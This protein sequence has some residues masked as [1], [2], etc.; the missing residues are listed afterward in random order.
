MTSVDR[1]T[2]LRSAAL[3]AAAAA[4]AACS[5]GGAA[6]PAPTAAAPASGHSPPS[7]PDGG[8]S[9]P[10]TAGATPALPA[11]MPFS[12]TAGPR[13]RPRVA[14]TFHG[15]GAPDLTKAI[16]DTTSA[17]GARI[18]VMA[19]GTWLDEQPQLA[20]S[21]LDGGNELGNHTLT[22]GNISGMTAEAAYAEIAGCADRLKRL[23][24]SPGRWFR[25][26]RAEACT[27]V[28]AAQ[29]RRAGYEHCLGYDL[30]SLDY[31]DPGA[32][33]VR[34]TVLDRVRPGSVVSLH[35][36]HRGTVEALP[37]ILAG[38]RARGLQAVT[39]TE[40]FT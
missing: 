21:V 16:L 4:V 23:T 38:L 29:A 18:T 32:A 39:A 35:L 9:P 1:R 22:H 40:L 19:V 20:R 13:D 31:T 12:I 15:Q 5:R 6:A 25:P 10:T 7:G 34:Q 24:G 27:P 37:A 11:G 17:A 26:S 8:G 3:G 14:L 33:A 36:G 28:V 30:D 2:L